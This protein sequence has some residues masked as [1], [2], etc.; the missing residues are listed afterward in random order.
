MCFCYR[1]DHHLY[2]FRRFRGCYV[3][4][5]ESQIGLNSIVTFYVKG[6]WYT[7]LTVI[8]VTIIYLLLLFF[9]ICLIQVAVGEGKSIKI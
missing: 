8:I 2:P 9:I 1:K 3:N 4:R 7:Y 5:S 6:T